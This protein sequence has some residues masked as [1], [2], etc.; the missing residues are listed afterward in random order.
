VAQKTNFDPRAGSVSHGHLDKKTPD[1]SDQIESLAQDTITPEQILSGLQ[2]AER[3]DALVKRHPEFAPLIEHE[4][5]R[6]SLPKLAAT[7]GMNLPDLRRLLARFKDH[8]NRHVRDE[9]D[10]PS[11]RDDLDDEELQ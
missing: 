8:F 4:E 2:M 7:L 9:N 10:E 5:L 11:R 6:K 1:S 3:L